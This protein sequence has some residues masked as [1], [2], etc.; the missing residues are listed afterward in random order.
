[1][2]RSAMIRVAMRLL[3]SCEN[4]EAETIFLWGGSQRKADD[5]T[6]SILF[7]KLKYIRT[8]FRQSVDS[9]KRSGHG[10]VVWI[11]YE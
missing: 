8:K 2:L 3:Q 5:I 10:R 11:H 7:E 9:G 1:M 4:S 6:K